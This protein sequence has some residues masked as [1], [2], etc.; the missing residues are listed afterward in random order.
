MQEYVQEK[1]NKMGTP[2]VCMTKYVYMILGGG[3]RE[4]E[5][6]RKL[7]QRQQSISISNVYS[8]AVSTSLLESIRRICRESKSTS[9]A[10]G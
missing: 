8:D 1:K 10:P 3:G 2:N 9:N 5:G 7:K 4:E 6:D